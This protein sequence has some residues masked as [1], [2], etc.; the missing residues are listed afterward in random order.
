MTDRPGARERILAAA[1]TLFTRQGINATGMDQL[2]ATAT[3]SKRTV[4]THFRTK[5]DLVLAYLAEARPTPEQALDRTDRPARERLLAI[6]EPR[7]DGDD[8]RRGCPFLNAA[9]E[10]PDPDAPAH[11]F[12]RQ[13]KVE[14]ARRLTETAREAGA[15]D[16]ET[17]GEQL[18]LLYDGAAGRAVVMNSP[19]PGARAREIAELL[20]DAQLR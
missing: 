17:L 1:A 12:A 9:V 3:A 10:V 6:F 14:F 20:I 5:D 16:P 13:H 15:R 2:S 7:A 11:A 4:Y 8:P 18:A 19:A